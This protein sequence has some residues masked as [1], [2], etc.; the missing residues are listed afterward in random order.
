VKDKG[1]REK[2]VCDDASVNRKRGA[3]EDMQKKGASEVYAR[4]KHRARYGRD[5]GRRGVVDEE[6]TEG[7]KCK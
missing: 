1:E 4:S 6:A 3:K 5:W 7:E 2:D